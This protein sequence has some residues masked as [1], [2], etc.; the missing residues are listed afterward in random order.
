M[1]AL[2]FALRL[3]A[4]AAKLLHLPL[5]SSSVDLVEATPPSGGTAHRRWWPHLNITHHLSFGL[6]FFNRWRSSHAR[7]PPSPSPPPP[8][9]PPELPPRL[10]GSNATEP[11]VVPDTS[12]GVPA[13]VV[14]LMYAA[15]SAAIVALLARSTQGKSKGYVELAESG[16]QVPTAHLAGGSEEGAGAPST[17]PS[18]VAG[19]IPASPAV[20]VPG[21]VTGSAIQSPVSSSA[22]S[23]ASS[24]SNLWA[25]GFE[26]QPAMKASKVCA[27]PHTAPHTLATSHEGEQGMR[28][29]AHATAY[30]R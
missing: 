3:L 29:A 4:A 14:F 5:V 13:I 24:S 16:D 30:T 22:N 25:R 9:P 28:L 12:G 26:S 11:S 17:A 1:C 23:S 20:R 8:F 7:P 21:T 6:P 18:T 27:S 2:T 15:L 19:A 10:P